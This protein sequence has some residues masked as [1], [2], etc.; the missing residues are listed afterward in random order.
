M[1]KYTSVWGHMKS[2]EI[3]YIYIYIYI[4]FITERGTHHKYKESV[5]QKREVDIH[6]PDQKREM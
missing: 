2:T 4:Y 1:N 5:K 6:K 3:M